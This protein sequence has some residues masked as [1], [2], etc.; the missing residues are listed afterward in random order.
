M[1]DRPWLQESSG[2]LRVE[3]DLLKQL[4]A[5][6]PPAGS[7]DRGWATLSASLPAAAAP[8]LAAASG[9]SALVKVAAGLALAGGAAW[10][11]TALL[12]TPTPPPAHV[13]V[14]AHVPLPSEPAV[15][16]PAQPASDGSPSAREDKPKGVRPSAPASS[17]AE[18]GR[19]LANAHR[20]V[21]QGKPAEALEALRALAARY[22]RSV[23]S[24]EREVLTI[25][26]LGASGD[27]RTARTRAETF[28]RRHPDSPHAARL[29]RFVK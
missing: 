17:L 6:E 12:D 28:L 22:P 15:S 9:V 21:Q 5:L 19:L 7:V 29:Q 24:Q 16:A 1:S 26:A 23:L 13:P 11:G 4:S 8:P 25:E 18:E 20:L 10:A 27:A 2:A 14:A 3:R